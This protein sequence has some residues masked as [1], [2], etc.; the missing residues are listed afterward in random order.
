[1]LLLLLVAQMGLPCGTIC[2]CA[3]P[4]SP[5][6]TAGRTLPVRLQDRARQGLDLTTALEGQVIGVRTMTAQLCRAVGAAAPKRVDELLTEWTG[7]ASVRAVKPEPCRISACL[8]CF[9]HSPCCANVQNSACVP[10]LPSIA[11]TT[12]DAAGRGCVGS[13]RRGHPHAHS[14]R[15]G[16]WQRHG[17]CAVLCCAA[18]SCRRC[19]C[20]GCRCCSC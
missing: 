3:C 5:R 14:S 9:L 2:I 8:P 17:E 15:A 16:D 20:R 7:C 12:T 13:H 11:M 4:C 6:P 19:C 1:M 10:A 18:L